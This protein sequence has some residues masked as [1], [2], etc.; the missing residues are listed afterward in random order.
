MKEY[1]SIFMEPNE[2]HEQLKELRNQLHQYNHQYYILNN[3]EVSDFEYDQ[4][5]KELILLEEKHPEFHDINS[6]SVRVGSDLNKAFN[7]VLHKYPML[8]LGN[9]YSENELQDFVHRVERSLGHS[10]AFVCELKYD[11]TA[12]SLTYENGH[13]ISGVTRGDGERGDDVTANVRTIRNI[14][15]KLQGD[16]PPLFEIRGEIYMPRSGF[17]EFNNERIKAGEQPFVNPRNAAAGSLKLQNSALVAKRPLECFLYYLLSESP[18]TTSHY[19][20]LKAVESWGL[21]VSPHIERCTTV[22]QIIAFIRKWEVKRHEL[23][24]DI[25]GVVIKVDDLNQRE[26]L[27]FTAKSPRWAI[28]YKFQAESVFTQLLSVDFQ[29]GRTG[30]VTPVANLQPVYLAG[31]TVK[32][33]SLHNADIISNLDLH[34]NDTVSLE[35]GGEIIPKITG[36]DTTKRLP[37]SKVVEFITHCPECNT[38]LIRLDGEAAHYCPNSANCPPQIK[39][40][41]EHF[42]H[43]RA[44]NI[45]SLGTETISL[46][47]DE[48]LLKSVSDL[49]RLRP[50][51]L[52]SLERMGEKSASN[53]I[54]SIAES[55]NVP[56]DRVLFALGIR[57]VGE[58]VAKKLVAA[59]PSMETI[60]KASKEELMEVD[61]IGERIAGSLIAYFSIEE[62]RKLI[63]DLQ[64]FGVQFEQE[65]KET[66]NLSKTLEG[67]SIVVSGV[68]NRSRD[69]I[70]ELIEAHGGK[71]ISAISKKT[72][73]VLAGEKMGPAKLERAT[74]LGITIL[75]EEQ[76]FQLIES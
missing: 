16:F 45:E 51:Q 66:A 24:Y 54:Q 37:E 4:K 39:A 26:E 6:P 10:T 20:N 40:K 5:M 74:K 35:K 41:I 57:F 34:L 12:I 53:I 2:V 38:P 11:G 23:P 22:E 58:T 69:E 67:K 14:P 17:E 30:A 64:N 76:F 61:E 42:I 43:R 28:S 65:I 62:N 46:L 44:M 29:V 55:K 50:S 72:D 25:D 31:T 59:M 21:R 52:S 13:L 1:N 3:P 32:R 60:M 63:H 7:T 70:K 8:S 18:P 15:L 73:F 68:F 36:I 48:G 9:T 49:Y 75:S 71:N 47:Y 27:G 33:A 19:E 56:F